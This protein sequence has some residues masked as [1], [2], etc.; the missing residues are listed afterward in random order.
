MGAGIPREF[1]V[2]LDAL[3]EHRVATSAFDVEGMPAGETT[4]IT[5]DPAV[6]WE[7]TPPALHR[8]LFLPI[9]ASNSLATVMARKSGGRVDGFIIEGPTAGGHNAPPRGQPQFNERGEPI[10]GPRDQVDL[11]K[12]RELGLPFWLA[13]GKGSPAGLRQ[14]LA[15][16]AA[17][18][19][20]GTLFAYCEESGHAANLKAS[21]ISA[22]ARNVVDVIT[23]PRASPTGFPFKVVSWD[24]NPADWEHRER[25]CDLGYLRSAY[26][27]PD[28]KIRF[29]CA[30]EP[31]DTYLS[32]G[33]N[34][35]ETEGRKCLCN[36]LMANIG[37]E[38]LRDDGKVEPP[39]LT[40]GDDLKL[41]GAYLDGRSSYSAADVVAYLLDNDEQGA[42]AA[43][44][45]SAQ[46][47]L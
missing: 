17:G 36:A 23:D 41:M 38:Q 13:G 24:E 20:V 37:L 19:Q 10:Y 39:L 6:H 11:A 43:Y 44:R 42:Q 34:T 21:V 8:P 32:K 28:G 33:G 22:A 46:E 2:A 7:L 1:P 35:E 26:H 25:I 9:I 16:G 18:I 4:H 5:F 31:V 30:S 27:G 40:S 12:M 15:E 45:G 47:V 29:R 3:A 14:A